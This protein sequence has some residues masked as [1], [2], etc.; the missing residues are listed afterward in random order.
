MQVRASTGGALHSGQGRNQSDR[1][2]GSGPQLY[3]V[4]APMT[5][6][7]G[8]MHLGGARVERKS[9]LCWHCSAKRVDGA[10]GPQSHKAGKLDTDTTLAP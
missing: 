9:Q 3:R 6:L 2:I 7:F 8:A 10:M 1:R 5:A 4:E